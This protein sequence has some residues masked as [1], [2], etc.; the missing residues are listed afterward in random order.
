[1]IMRSIGPFPNWVTSSAR[2]STEAPNTVRFAGPVVAGGDAV[3][4]GDGAAVGDDVDLDGGRGVRAG[5]AR[6]VTVDVAVGGALRVGLGVR[7]GEAPGV[8]GGADGAPAS[9]ITCGVVLAS[10]A[11]GRASSAGI[12]NDVSR[13][14]C[15]VTEP[16][17]PRH[18]TPRTTNTRRW[19]LL[20]S[21]GW[22]DRLTIDILF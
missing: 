7:M 4:E 6:R 15:T 9:A 13:S 10:A 17:S 3:D 11:A 12:P 18:S 1:M 22:L 14:R 8:A 5:A 21:L 2:P 19:I 16:S 20:S